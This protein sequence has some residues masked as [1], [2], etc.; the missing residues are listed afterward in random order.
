[1]NLYDRITSAPHSKKNQD[2]STTCSRKS[3]QKIQ[4]SQKSHQ[5]QKNFRINSATNF[6][7][8]RRNSEMKAM[9]S[10]R[11]GSSRSLTHLG[12]KWAQDVRGEDSF[13][14]NDTSV[15]FGAGI[16]QEVPKWLEDQKTPANDYEKLTGGFVDEITSLTSLDQFDKFGKPIK[17]ERDQYELKSETTS[18]GIVVISTKVKKDNKKYLF[19]SNCGDKT[20]SKA[21][22]S[23]CMNISDAEN[24]DAYFSDSDS[25]SQDDDLQTK[26]QKVVSTKTLTSNF[27]KMGRQSTRLCEPKTFASKKPTT[28]LSTALLCL[29]NV[30]TSHLNKQE[31]ANENSNS[32]V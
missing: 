9:P 28:N 21:N 3:S 12:Q 32:S 15:D 6:H 29:R 24:S 4:E 23:R 19:K 2:V 16:I 25:N 31:S 8:K 1:M 27:Q 13:Q 26:M 11:K 17:V 22:L 10:K 20:S 30:S 14:Q 18:G 5:S 7:P